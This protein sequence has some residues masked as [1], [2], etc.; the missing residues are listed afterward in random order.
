MARAKKQSEA[1]RDPWLARAKA[2][3]ETSTSFI[4]TIYRKNWDDNIRHF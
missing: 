1:K 3:F 4:D 2:A